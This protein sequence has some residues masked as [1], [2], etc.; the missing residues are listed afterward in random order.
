MMKD[1]LERL[2]ILD[3]GLEVETSRTRKCIR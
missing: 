3:F 1:L 2:D